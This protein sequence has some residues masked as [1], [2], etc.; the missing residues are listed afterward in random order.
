M[1]YF[2]K[3]NDLIPSDKLTFIGD[4]VAILA[5]AISVITL[6]LTLFMSGK[7]FVFTHLALLEIDNIENTSIFK[8]TLNLKIKLRNIGLGP[9]YDVILTNSPHQLK[10]VGPGET[11]TLSCSLNNTDNL[12]QNFYII[13]HNAILEYSLGTLS[14]NNDTHKIQ[15]YSV[16]IISRRNYR[17]YKNQ[18]INFITEKV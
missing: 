17:K 18:W 9:V 16:R 2:G 3:Q 13:Y 4:F 1:A 12:I 10:Y 8:D 6:Y 5:C 15:D 14:L 11:V 7:Q